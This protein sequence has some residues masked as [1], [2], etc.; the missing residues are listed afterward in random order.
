M[1]FTVKDIP[2]QVSGQIARTYLMFEICQTCFLASAKVYIAFCTVSPQLVITVVKMS[3][4]RLPEPTP[5][6]QNNNNNNNNCTLV[7]LADELC[8]CKWDS[9][10]WRDLDYEWRELTRVHCGTKPGRF[11]TFNLLAWEQA[12]E[13]AVRANKRTDERV[14]QHRFWAILNHT[15]LWR[16]CGPEQP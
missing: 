6:N 13:L 7:F 15:G 14:A 8:V 11:E 5:K 3:V 10:F 4:T 16:H 2:R 1:P 9:W 12:N